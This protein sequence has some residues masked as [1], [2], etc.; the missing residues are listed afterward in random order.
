MDLAPLRVP[1]VDVPRLLVLVGNVDGGGGGGG[2]AVNSGL[3]V[4]EKAPESQLLLS[5]EEDITE[6]ED[7]CKRSLCCC[8][9]CCCCCCATA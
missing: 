4:R 8:C 1:P 7:E 6:L 3:E 5:A 9:C 2:G